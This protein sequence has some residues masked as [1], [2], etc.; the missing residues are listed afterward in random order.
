[1]KT[2]A[3]LLIIFGF[4]YSLYAQEPSNEM[5]QLT[6]ITSGLK[7]RQISSHDKTGGNADFVGKINDG[8]KFELLNVTGAGVINRIWITIAPEGNEVSRYDLII[9]MYWD[10]NTYPSVESPL[11]PFFGN[12]WN[13]SYNFVTLPL[14][15]APG[16]GKSYVS[17]FAMPFATGA[18]I[19]I[20][21]QSGRL[22]DNFYYNIG[23]TE[24]EELPKI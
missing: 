1:M 8:E 2:S 14:S 18:R 21:N 3:L 6:K 7:T 23:Y 9:R 12:G 15:I 10:G 24:M 11:G 13:E 4:A 17:Y 19:E 16:A 20:E 22:I 5:M